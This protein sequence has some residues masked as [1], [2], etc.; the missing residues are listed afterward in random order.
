MF[1][2]IVTGFGM[3]GLFTTHFIIPGVGIT[4]IIGIG[5]TIT[6]DGIDH[7]VLGIT[8]IATQYGT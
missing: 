6:M 7:T 8:S 1:T 5:R 4:G 2:F 3:I